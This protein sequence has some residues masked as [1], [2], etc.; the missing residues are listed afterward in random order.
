MYVL[1]TVLSTVLPTVLPTVLHHDVTFQ[2]E[3]RAPVDEVVCCCTL[4]MLFTQHLAD[5]NP[6]KLVL[7]TVP[8]T[9]LDCP[10]E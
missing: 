3:A 5:D 6:R 9:V 1:P 8:P 2:E 4:C 10:Q 7:P